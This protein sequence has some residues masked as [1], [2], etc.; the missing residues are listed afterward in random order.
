MSS[1]LVPACRAHPSISCRSRSAPGIE[2]DQGE[3]PQHD[4]TPA[5]PLR[6]ALCRAP[7]TTAAARIRIAGRHAHVFC[8]PAGLVFEIGCFSSAEG[9]AAI[10]PPSSEFTWFPEHFW[11][12]AVC[13]RCGTHLGWRFAGPAGEFWGLILEYLV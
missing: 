11:Q 5:T 4:Q 10:G 8:N 13:T 3:A 7:V 12:V 2:P 9:C 6:C 1:C